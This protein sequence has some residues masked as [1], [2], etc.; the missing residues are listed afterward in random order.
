MYQQPAKLVLFFVFKCALLYALFVSPLFAVGDAYRRGF[1]A[2]GN[3]MFYRVGAPG[4]VQFEPLERAPEG[5]DTRVVLENRRDRRKGALEIRSLYYGYRPMAFL[6]AL[7]LATPIS[8]SRRGRALLWGLV[9]INLFVALRVWLRVTDAFCDPKMLGLYDVSQL[10]RS[11]LHGVMLVISRAPATSYFAPLLV[12]GLVTFRR[13][14]WS[15][16]Q[17]GRALRAGSDPLG[18]KPRLREP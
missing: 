4:L 5:K 10:W 17:A 12:W 8:W 9:W 14:D 18:T 7:I 11:V 16:I 15:A 2:V 3:A 6:I 1:R 13:G